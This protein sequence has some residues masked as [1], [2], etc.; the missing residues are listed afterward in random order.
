MLGIF[1]D[2]IASRTLKETDFFTCGIL[3]TGKHDNAAYWA[4]L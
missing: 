3:S 1:D 2:Q 4:G